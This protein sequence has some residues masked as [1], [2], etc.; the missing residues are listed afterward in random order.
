LSKEKEASRKNEIYQRL[1]EYKLN[2]FHTARK[3]AILELEDYFSPLFEK[4]QNN[5]PKERY[6]DFNQG[7]DA[8]ILSKSPEKIKKLSEIP[9][10]PLRIAF[11]NWRLR[12]PYE[13]A[14]RMAAE[15]GITNMSNYLLY[16]YDDKPVDLYRRLKLNVD[17]CEELGISIYSFPMKY[18]PIDDPKYFHNR[19]YLGKH[20]NRKFIRA[21]QAVLNST[22]G[23]IGRGK[24]FF[25]KAFGKNE[26]EFEKLLYMPEAM[27]I[28]RFFYEG[29]GLTDEWYDA[30]ISLS[31]EKLS[32]IK[33]II[34]INVFSD[35]D[36]LTS[37][38]EILKVLQYYTIHREDA[39][40][41]LNALENEIAD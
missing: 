38:P 36:D 23:K 13:I 14:V 28:Y 21:I 15:N 31:P 16:N 35:I 20:W 41:V 18:H 11:D 40:K 24:Q 25:E 7:V 1:K 32:I 33:P 12:K 22:K 27:I 19:F 10:R 3:E 39:E 30:F 26:A 8:R 5:V 6:V 17:L 9:I 2:N 29:N 37:D 34:H 4:L